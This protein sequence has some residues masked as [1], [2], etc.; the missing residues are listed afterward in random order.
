MRG[1]ID[2]ANTDY[3][4]IYVS[5]RQRDMEPE[6]NA[7]L[8]AHEPVHTVSLNGVAFAHTYDLDVIPPP[9]WLVNSHDCSFAFADAVQL[10]AFHRTPAAGASSTLTLFFTSLP[11]ATERYEVRIDLV[12]KGVSVKGTTR[13]APLLPAA[14]TGMLSTV[15]YP[16]TIPPD[17]TLGD[18]Y[19]IVTVVDPAT[20]QPIPATQV[21]T[22]H[23]SQQALMPRC[24]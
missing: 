12:T 13:T 5:Q 18:Y 10:V 14:A 3:A 7:Y 6:F 17:H 4:T 24:R 23:T 20:K 9:A 2:W 1:V 11:A 8:S 22:G 15:D 16:L 19:L 21:T